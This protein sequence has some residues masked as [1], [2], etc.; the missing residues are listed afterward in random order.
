MQA[1]WS[2]L[3]NLI[4]ST[5]KLISWRVQ[6]SYVVDVVPYIEADEATPFGCRNRAGK[7]TL[8]FQR[9]YTTE[10]LAMMAAQSLRNSLKAVAAGALRI[11]GS[12]TE[13]AVDIW[14]T[15]A[16]IETSD[17]YSD[18]VVVYLALGFVVG[19]APPGVISMPGT[20]GL[21]IWNA[22]TS[23]WCVLWGRG[24]GSLASPFNLEVVGPSGEETGDAGGLRVWNPDIAADCNVVARGDGSEVDPFRLEITAATGG[25]SVPQVKNIDTGSYVSLRARGAGTE[26]NPFR[27]EPYES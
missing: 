5:D 24:L 19:A 3:T 25:P 7:R 14:D 21:R 27:L 2:S 16:A 13:E 15:W 12:V 6:D 22:D 1:S 9:D 17:I 18:G 20:I 8:I 10:W 4:L 26:E 11:R 23:A